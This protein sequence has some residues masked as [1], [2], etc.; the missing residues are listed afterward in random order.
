MQ[1]SKELDCTNWVA[2][3][4]FHLDSDSYFINAHYTNS[5]DNKLYVNKNLGT[6]QW[7]YMTCIGN[8]ETYT[9]LQ[10]SGVIIRG[11]KLKELAAD[12]R[13]INSMTHYTLRVNKEGRCFVRTI[14]VGDSAHGAE[15]PNAVFVWS[16]YGVETANDKKQLEEKEK[17][18]M[19]LKSQ[20]TDLEKELLICNNKLAAAEER[21]DKRMESWKLKLEWMDE[22]VSLF[23]KRLER[24]NNA[25][26]E[27]EE[28]LEAK[29]VETRSLKC[30]L[31]DAEEELSHC[32]KALERKNKVV[33]EQD[34]AGE[35][36]EKELKEWKLRF[37]QLEDD[38][39][40]R[41]KDLEFDV[42]VLD[43]KKEFLGKEVK[44][45]EV[46]MSELQGT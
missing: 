46:K 26:K 44:G 11:D 2:M 36:A 22:E 28:A 17:Q 5:A 41:R 4:V 31:K 40:I 42:K 14:K 7:E 39:C 30:Q 10:V 33:E 29:E 35:E 8:G 6:E 15:L 18:L 16:K 23:V 9:E 13:P 43:M 21:D 37:K 25:L 20:V 3:A 19:D 34:K 32:K 27:V 12:L 24:K 38:L 1:I 45:L